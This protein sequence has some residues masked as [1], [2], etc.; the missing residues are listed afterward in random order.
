MFAIK[1]L[2][3]VKVKYERKEVQQLQSRAAKR[4][5]ASM[6][7]FCSRFSTTISCEINKILHQF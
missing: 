4:K 1:F 2:V 7:N 6:Q 3:C 5:E